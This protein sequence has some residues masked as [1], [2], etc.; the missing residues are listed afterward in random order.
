[1]YDRKITNSQHQTDKAT[2]DDGIKLEIG[3]KLEKKNHKQTFSCN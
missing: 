2:S 1:M 3:K